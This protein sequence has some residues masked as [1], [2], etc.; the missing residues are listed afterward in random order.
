MNVRI[1]AGSETG[2]KETIQEI[3]KTL[4]L[5]CLTIEEAN[6]VIV[7]VQKKLESISV[8]DA[9]KILYTDNLPKI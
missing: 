1:I 7:E 9:Y 4:S 8:M 3:I 2:S 6:K 5:H